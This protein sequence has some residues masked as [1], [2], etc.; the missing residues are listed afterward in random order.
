M[1]YELIG[2]VRSS[3]S[4]VELIRLTGRRFAQ[5]EVSTRSKSESPCLAPDCYSHR[6]PV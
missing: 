1:L 6:P 3:P 2:V 5:D 4:C